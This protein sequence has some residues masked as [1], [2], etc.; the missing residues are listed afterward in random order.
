MNLDGRNG[1]NF[2]VRKNLGHQFHKWSRRGKTD[3]VRG[4]V[5]SLRHGGTERKTGNIF[6]HEKHERHEINMARQD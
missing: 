1:R 2:F 3:W 4:K 6:N 5:L